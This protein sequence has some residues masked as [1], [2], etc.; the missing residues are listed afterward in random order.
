MK[1]RI[2]L[3][4]LMAL[5]SLAVIAC[6]PAAAPT[7][8]P[9]PAPTGGGAAAADWAA[10]PMAQTT[11]V[12]L[13]VE[14]GAQEQLFLSYVGEIKR[15]LNID[16]KVVAH[17]F[18]DQYQIQYL[19]L[20]TGSGQY[21][22]LS[23]WP[24]YLAD[25][26][27]YLEPL[28]NIRPGG[29]DAVYKDLHLDDVFPAYKS[30]QFYKGKVYGITYDGDVKLL[31]YRHDL[32]TDPKEMAAFKAKYGYDLNMDNLTW[33]QYLDV[34]QFFQRPDQ[35]L[36]GTAEISGF[37]SGW[38]FRDRYMGMGGHYFDYAS[39]KAFP[40]QDAC[41]KAAQNI[42]DTV[43]KGEA[44]EAKSFEFE[45]ARNQIIKDDRAFMVPQW[46]DV[47]KWANDGNLGSAKAVGNVW[48]AEM[49]GFKDAK[50]GNVVHR[51]EMNGGRVI[52]VNKASKVKEA[53]YKVVAFF[54]DPDLS[55]RIVYNNTFWDDPWRL[56][57]VAD[58]SLLTSLGKDAAGRQ[59]YVDVLKKSSQDAYPYLQIPGVGKYYE[60]QER[61]A[62][63]LW[64]GQ[65]TAADACKGMTQEFDQITD[66]IG[67]DKQVKEYQNY[68][69]SVLVPLNINDAKSATQ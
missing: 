55:S 64:A 18:A 6:A 17:P 23:H 22:V 7:A 65:L 33:D 8:A 13:S 41:V 50:T 16:L 44:P 11:Q 12:V 2:L 35:K 29:A 14:A 31:N 37:L 21:D 36:F 68:V 46:P 60:V 34:A 47:W 42:I 62:K 27:P 10:Q 48:V 3:I 61:Y 5:M 24:L 1:N 45:D 28:E 15:K 63:Q 67:R 52:T 51:P 9:A 38:A 25:F 56:S 40:Q 32:A 69:D 58:L 26:G 53:A 19:D 54:G 30:N 49:P 57:H 43:T 4:A 59:N 39:M 20:T 66:Q